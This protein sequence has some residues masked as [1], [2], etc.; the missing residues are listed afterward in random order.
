MEATLKKWG[1][2]QGVLIPKSLCEYLGITI[3]DRLEVNEEQGAITM[4][5]AKKQF[6][7]SHKLTATELFANWDEGYQP[8]AD[9]DSRGAEVDWGAPAKGEM[10]W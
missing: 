5:P 8:P 6:T 1:N 4:R 7:R 10:P 2:S 3:G 9:W